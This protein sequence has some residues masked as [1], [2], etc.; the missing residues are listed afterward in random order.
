MLH[1]I[2]QKILVYQ[3]HA[4]TGTF[5]PLKLPSITNYVIY[6][7][8]IRKTYIMIHSAWYFNK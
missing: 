2:P 1:M 4:N 5:R 8:L 3:N 7:R 6:K